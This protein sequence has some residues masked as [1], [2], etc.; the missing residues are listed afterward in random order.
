MTLRVRLVVF[1]VAA[2]GVGAL[3]GAAIAGLPHFGDYRGPY[4]FVLNRIVVPERHTTNV[5]S[6]TTFDYRGIDTMGEEFIL[7]AAV[8][9][10]SMLL[11]AGGERKAGSPEAAQWHGSDAIR[12]VAALMVGVVFV[13]GLW[14]VAFGY[15]TPGGGFQGGVVLAGAVV[16]LYVAS[17]Y[18]AYEP[19]A[20][21]HALD[22][23][24]MVGAGGYVVIG[25][26]ALASSLPFLANL[27][28]PGSVGTLRSGGSIPF[29]NW[30]TG[31]EVTAATL[32]LFAEFLKEY[33][34]PLPK[35][36]G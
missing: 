32:V 26:A 4:G 20:N 19:F 24:E 35:G 7:L 8:L 16:L 31:I 29:L 17:T 34:A 15:V 25:I 1:L 22:P 18:R 27:F 33:V 12:I 5:V 10:V 3:F 9:G 21:E 30:A 13:V 28:G 36:S 23:I 2:S 11:R 6:A 14:L